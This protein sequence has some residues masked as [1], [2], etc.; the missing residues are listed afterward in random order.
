MTYGD[1]FTAALIAAYAVGAVLYVYELNGPK[2]LYFFGAAVLT[3]GV[4]LME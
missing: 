2:A 3:L 1:W 4:L